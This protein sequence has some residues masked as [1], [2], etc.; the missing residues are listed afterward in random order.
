MS[1]Y[2]WGSDVMLIDTKPLEIKSTNNLKTG[3]KIFCLINFA[4]KGIAKILISSLFRWKYV[5]SQLPEPL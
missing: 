2:S 3:L 1:V 4:N 5:V